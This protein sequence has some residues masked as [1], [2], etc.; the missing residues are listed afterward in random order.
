[1]V[2][3]DDWR[4][5]AAAVA[6]D[7]LL[8]GVVGV[9]AAGDDVGG[10]M[11]KT[12]YYRDGRQ[13]RHHHYCWQPRPPLA[14]YDRRDDCAHDYFAPASVATYCGECFATPPPVVIETT[15]K[16]ND[17]HVHNCSTMS[18]YTYI[19]LVVVGRSLATKVRVAILDHQN[20]F[21]LAIVEIV[22]LA[23]R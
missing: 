18:T 13:Q 7:D 14:D 15:T 19:A 23:Y 1:M 17:H 11:K 4:E 22:Q 6:S 8:G 3:H 20:L 12:N 2:E 21:H 9:A 16:G 5:V 10:W